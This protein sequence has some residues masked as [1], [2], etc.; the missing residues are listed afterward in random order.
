MKQKRIRKII[1][2]EFINLFYKQRLTT[3]EICEHFNVTKSSIGSIRRRYNLPPRGWAN[4]PFL[5]KH[6]SK[7]TKNKI[8]I[9]LKGKRVKA[10]NPNWRGGFYI[11]TCG[12]KLIYSDELRAI[13][14][15]PYILEHRFNVEKHIGRK[16]FNFEVIHHINGN[17]IDNRIEN[18]VLTNKSLHAKLHSP[19]GTKFGINQE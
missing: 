4:H 7:E 9:K 12:Y 15:Y 14:K 18:L 13:G 11:N 17:K 1:L 10:K 2:N 8:S 5:N 19:K 16:L 3:K 6:H